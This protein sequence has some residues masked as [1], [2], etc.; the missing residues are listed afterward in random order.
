MRDLKGEDAAGTSDPVVFVEVCEAGTRRARARAVC[1]LC[2][3]VW[4]G[5]RVM[6]SRDRAWW[7]GV[8]AEGVDAGDEEVPQRRV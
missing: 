7:A 4:V 2:A 1:A 8:R 6:G 5:P 3:Q